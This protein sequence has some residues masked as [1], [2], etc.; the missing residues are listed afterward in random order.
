MLGIDDALIREIGESSPPLVAPLWGCE[1]VASLHLHDRLRDAAPLREVGYQ[2]RGLVPMVL[3]QL[4]VERPSAGAI[5]ERLWG[6]VDAHLGAKTVEALATDVFCGN[7]ALA[8]E[9]A[10]PLANFTR[11]ASPPAP[12]VTLIG[13]RG[14]LWPEQAIHLPSPR[15]M[16]GGDARPDPLRPSVTTPVIHREVPVGE[17][18]AR[19]RQFRV[20]L[21]A[22]EQIVR[23]S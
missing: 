22:S 12:S 17:L 10:R 3:D 21:L 15:A 5:V 6:P 11:H 2:E 8:A 20:D 9:P 4:S 18:W 23:R 19:L 13:D 16:S 7:H 1:V 14:R